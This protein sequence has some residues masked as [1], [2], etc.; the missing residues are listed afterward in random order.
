MVTAKFREAP[1]RFGKETTLRQFRYF[2]TTAEIGQFRWLSPPSMCRNRPCPMRCR[3][4]SSIRRSAVRVPAARRRADHRRSPVLLA[5]KILDSEEDALRESRVQVHELQGTVH[6][7]ASCTVL[8]DFPARPAG[9]RT[10]YP[11]RAWG[12]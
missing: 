7:T 3:H 11:D 10:N 6:L 12:A 5:W 4:S 2:A 9:A 1:Q 8:G